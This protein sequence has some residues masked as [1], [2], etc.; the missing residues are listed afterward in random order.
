MRVYRIHFNSSA[1]RWDEEASARTGV[2]G[3]FDTF[4]DF[5]SFVDTHGIGKGQTR[6]DIMSASVLLRG[7]RGGP[8]WVAQKRT[9]SF[10]QPPVHVLVRIAVTGGSDGLPGAGAAG[11]GV[12]GA[13]PPSVIEIT[14]FCIA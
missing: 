4:R 5:L 11:G 14:F 6:E 13:V 3:G 10:P 1:T 7:P 9:D 8:A 2:G 12:D